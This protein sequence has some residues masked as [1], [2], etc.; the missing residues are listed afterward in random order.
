MPNMQDDILAMRE[1]DR[2]AF[3]PMTETVGA[4][5]SKPQRARI[6]TWAMEAKSSPSELMRLLLMR[7]AEHYGRTLERT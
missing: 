7:G 2:Y 4:R 1:L 6:A 5:L 3:I